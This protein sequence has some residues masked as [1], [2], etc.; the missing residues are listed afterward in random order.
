[1]AV[2]LASWAFGV[3]SPSLKVLGNVSVIVVGV[4]IASFDEIQFDLTGFL[5][6]LG[7]ITFEALRLVLVQ[8]LLNSAEY[9]MDPLVSL[10]YFAPVCALMNGLVSLFTEFPAMTMDDVYHVGIWTLLANAMI[11]F[12]LNVAV[13]FLVY[14]SARLSST[15]LTDIFLD[16]QN[17]LPRLHSVR[18]PEGHPPCRTLGDDLGYS[19]HGISILWLRYCFVWD[20]VFQVWSGTDQRVLWSNT[21]QVG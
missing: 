3:A 2:L 7:G 20:D 1:M 14:S 15:D 13:V 19:S 18:C 9:K 6:Q 21:D 10:Y 17:I 12:L 16:Q 5:Y 4:V 11:A 8:K